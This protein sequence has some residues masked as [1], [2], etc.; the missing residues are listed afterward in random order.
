VG[1]SRAVWADYGTAV[2]GRRGLL[3]YFR[4][5]GDL[6]RV[7]PVFGSDGLLFVVFLGH[8]VLSREG[9]AT[10]VGNGGLWIVWD[11]C[12]S[13]CPLYATLLV[14]GLTSL[15]PCGCPGMHGKLLLA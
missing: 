9:G 6:S 3:V 15:R 13:C 7:S 1:C 10:L 2:T 14:S 8:C 12:L 5:L 4:L 11:L